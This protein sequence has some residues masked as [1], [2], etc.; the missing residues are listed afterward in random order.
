[1]MN[2][3]WTSLV[4]AL[5]LC[6]GMSGV[7]LAQNWGQQSDRD[8]YNNAYSEPYGNY[9]RGDSNNR[10]ERFGYQ[11]GVIDGRNDAATGHS[12]RPTYDSSYRNATNGYS[13]YGSR[14]AYRQEYREA[15]MQGYQ[16]G[17][18]QRRGWRWGR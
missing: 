1:M 15:Y 2:N 11:D 14:G 18:G 17:Y 7:A 10:A 12:F 3:K 16:S 4:T 9:W 6:V 8:R 5:A 13:G